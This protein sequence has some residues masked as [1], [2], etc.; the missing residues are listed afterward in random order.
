MF[1]LP[2]HNRILCDNIFC[3]TEEDNPWPIPDRYILHTDLSHA[4]PI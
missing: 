3:H 4:V 2:C 1:C